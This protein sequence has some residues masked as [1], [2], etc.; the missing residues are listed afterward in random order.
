MAAHIEV[1][2]AIH[3]N[4]T[5]IKLLDMS[6]SLQS[7]FTEYLSHPHP[8]YSALEGFVVGNIQEKLKIHANIPSLGN[9]TSIS[10]L[11]LDALL[12]SLPAGEKFIN[13]SPALAPLTE[14]LVCGL[15]TASKDYLVG[16]E[17]K[18]NCNGEAA[19]WLQYWPRYVLNKYRNPVIRFS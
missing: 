7:D 17:P 13:N 8:Y 4:Q 5:D 18:P 14:S 12:K 3:L 11:A 6:S 15:E 16:W 9:C 10:Y 1:G 2:P 19:L